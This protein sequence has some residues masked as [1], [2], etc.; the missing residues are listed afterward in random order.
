MVIKLHRNNYP[1]II[2]VLVVLLLAMPLQAAEIK[3]MVDHDPVGLNETFTL[4]Y[5]LDQSPDAPPD[6]SPLHGNFD[7]INQGQSSST[8]WVNGKVTSSIKWKLVLRPL[9]AGKLEIPAVQFGSDSSTTMEITAVEAAKFRPRRDNGSEHIALEVE[10]SPQSAY[11]QQQ[12]IYTIRLLLNTNISSNSMLS[13]PRLKGA[14]AS[15][16]QM[17]KDSQYTT[18][19]QGSNWQVIE[20]RYAVTP[21]ASG[22]IDFEP[23]HF[24]GQLV[25]QQQQRPQQHDPFFNMFSTMHGPVK[26]LFSDPLSV[27]IKPRPDDFSGKLWLPASKLKIRGQWSKPHDELKTGEP[28]TLRITI[29]ADGLSAEQLSAPEVIFPAG[30]KSYN[31]QPERTDSTTKSGVRGVL[32]QKIAVVPT[33]SGSYSIPAIE[34]PWWNI[35][36]DKMEIARLDAIDIKASGA[37]VSSADPQPQSNTPQTDEPS[38]VTQAESTATAQT[39]QWWKTAALMFAL[40]WILSIAALLWYFK[41]RKPRSHKRADGNISKHLSNNLEV[42][43]K[44]GKGRRRKVVQAARSNDPQATR[45][46]LLKWGESVFPG[47]QI[48][49]LSSLV[50]Q[51]D[52]ELA[53][54]VEKLNLTLYSI[55]PGEWSGALLAEGILKWRES[56]NQDQDRQQEQLPPLNKL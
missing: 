45:N 15:I 17:G 23:A 8:S 34:I 50:Q 4:T 56:K 35:D 19:R 18:Q 31:D 36:T 53:G 14:K 43:T 47:V 20:R 11:V 1:I 44:F 24:E 40:L 41:L 52:G 3:T 7:L 32:V 39:D 48:H 28:A 51:L 46:A 10:T 9:R 13:P 33:K 22:V 5:E 6:F 12:I 2:A 29:E 37:D 42:V 21:L 26:H 30:L 55:D 49:S 54:E 38:S 27:E 25:Q 16:Q